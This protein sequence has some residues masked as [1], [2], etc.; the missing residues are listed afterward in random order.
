[1]N[2]ICATVWGSMVANRKWAS[3]QT[4][5]TGQADIRRHHQSWNLL[6]S[7]NRLLILYACD[8]SVPLQWLMTSCPAVQIN[9]L[10]WKRLK[11]S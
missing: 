10:A 11:V 6:N 4:M 2:M 5:T 8:K 9:P 7:A 3:V 1:M